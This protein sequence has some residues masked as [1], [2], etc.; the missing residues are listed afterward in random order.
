MKCCYQS[1]K[2]D[3]RS[4]E[5]NICASVNHSITI[6]TDNTKS[7]E[8]LCCCWFQLRIAPLELLLT[9]GSAPGLQV[10]ILGSWRCQWPR[11]SDSTTSW[12]QAW[13]RCV[14]PSRSQHGYWKTWTRGDSLAGDYVWGNLWHSGQRSAL[15]N[16]R[17]T[18]Y[19]AFVVLTG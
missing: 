14:R 17:T 18:M 4:H 12:W 7:R 5:G 10:F 19:H 15:F 2:N 9:G 6:P 1:L 3:W 13:K 16:P 11:Q 8:C